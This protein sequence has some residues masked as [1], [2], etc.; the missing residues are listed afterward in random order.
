MSEPKTCKD[1]QNPLTRQDLAVRGDRERCI[2]CRR[3]RWRR[4]A[5]ASPAMP[6]AEGTLITT[7][8]V[9]S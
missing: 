1:C 3:R 6:T 2:P 9:R 4:W 8:D 5:D 7:A